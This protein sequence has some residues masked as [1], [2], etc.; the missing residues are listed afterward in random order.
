MHREEEALVYRC[1]S[2]DR[3]LPDLHLGLY[4]DFIVFDQVQK[5]IVIHWVRLYRYSSIEEAY[6][7]GIKGLEILVSKVHDVDA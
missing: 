4:E 5:C 7:D 2:S 1:T 6:K 3:N